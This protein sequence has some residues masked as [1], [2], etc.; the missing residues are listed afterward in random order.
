MPE[1]DIGLSPLE[2]AY[3]GKIRKIQESWNAATRMQTYWPA[4]FDALVANGTS[5]TKFCRDYNF[6]NTTISN[7]MGGRR[8]GTMKYVRQVETALKAMGVDVDDIA[9]AVDKSREKRG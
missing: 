1:A 3:E 5:I 6:D 7:Q 2:K 8:G 4:F 9:R